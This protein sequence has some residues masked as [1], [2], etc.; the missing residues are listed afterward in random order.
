ILDDTPGISRI[1]RGRGFAYQDP[2]GRQIEDPEEIA[3]IGRLAIPPAWED[4]WICPNPSG[5]IQA[6]GRDARGRKQYRYHPDW[7]A[8]RDEI[9]FTRLIAFGESLPLLRE[10]VQADLRR[11]GLP[12]NKVLGLVVRLLELTLI[13]IGNDEYAKVNRSFGLTTLR[14]RHARVTGST[15]SFRFQGKGGHVLEVTLRD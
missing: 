8:W 9:K 7:R 5:H 14:N 3:R 13:R 10:R 6:T 15:V 2:N 1:R 4:V 11:R 12:R